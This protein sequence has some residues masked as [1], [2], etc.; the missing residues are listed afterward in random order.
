MRKLS[1]ADVRVGVRCRLKADEDCGA[2]SAVE[3]FA[4]EHQTPYLNVIIAHLGG[5]GSC[6]QDRTI[7][8]FLDE[9]L[10]HTVSG[11]GGYGHNSVLTDHL[12]SAEPAAPFTTNTLGDFPKKPKTRRIKNATLPTL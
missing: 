9:E 11:D 7:V 10:F 1:A 8:K 12:Y 6:S 5:E 2:V 4:R 3:R